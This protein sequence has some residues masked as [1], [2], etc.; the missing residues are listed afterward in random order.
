MTPRLP[1]VS[2]KDVL[3]A[4]LR[5]NFRLVDV[6]GSHHTLISPAGKL[7]TVPVHGKKILKP[8]TLKSILDQA[9][10]SV[11]QLMDLL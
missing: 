7:V 5:S 4:L 1:R 10:L 8:R 2:G 6:E 3:K 11:E 9:G